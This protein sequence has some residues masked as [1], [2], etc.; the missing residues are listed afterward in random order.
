MGPEYDYII[1]GAGTAGC[2]L[3]HRLSED[4]RHRVLLV[5]AGGDDRN[6]VLQ[7]PA[8]LRS[9]FK[10]TSRFNWWFETE[11]QA[12][13]DGRRISQPRGKA[14][15]GSSSINGMTFLRG[16]PLDYDQWADQLGCTG[17]S[18]AECLPYFKRSERFHGPA[19]PYRGQDGAVG[20]QRQEQLSPL[21]AA[22]LEAGQQ[23]GH[24]L[25]DD[26]NGY[27]QEGVA[28]FDMSVEGGMRSSSAREY[29][30]RQP[31]RDNLTVSSETKV[32]RLLIEGQ[33]VVGVHLSPGN[34]PARDVKAHR[35]VILSAGAFASPQL[36]M[37]SGIGPADH[38]E[39]CGIRVKHDLRGVGENLQDHLEAHIQVE[40]DAPVSLNRELRPDRMLW[41]GLSWF[42]AK[43]GMA[44][45]NQCHVGAFMR[46][47]ATQTHPNLQIHFFP[48]FF[49]AQWLPD[50]RTHG[51]RLGVGPMRPTS[52][53]TVRLNPGDPMGRPLIDPNYLATES[54]RQEMREGLRMSRDI[55]R[56][57]AFRP[58]H[59]RE[60]TPGRDCISDDE[61]D[62][63]IRRDASSAYHPCGTCRMGSDA[64]SV[65]DT[66]L[67]LRGI[68]GLRVVDASVI[69][70]L[71]T[72][73]INACVFM[74]AEKASDL[75]RGQTLPPEHLDYYRAQATSTASVEPVSDRATCNV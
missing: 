42:I 44:A 24:L 1:I 49:G 73:N 37:Q 3:A 22:F 41:A 11:P 13:L 39:D 30:H 53:G 75:I 52:R 4:G 60:D 26:V 59:R 35:E 21:N 66:E 47:D 27:R 56:Q 51:Y 68:E 69:P 40:T 55:L 23:A 64:D 65:V 25:V 5:E 16:N 46:S 38:L 45:V 50:R 7:M 58:F 61:L 10:P 74:I 18:Y 32:E 29:L 62:T 70:R 14:L 72:A 43:R 28:R 48:V 34:G 17:W 71:P 6:W 15:G 63:F 8:G 57:S 67:R 20:I 54:D 19:S 31:R 9:V 33:R 12:N 36:L 2:T